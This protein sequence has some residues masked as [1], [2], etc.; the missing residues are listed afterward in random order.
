MARI[1]CKYVGCTFLDEGLCSAT[2]I[3]LDPDEGCL[4]FTQVGDPFDDDED[5]GGNDD[6]DGYDEWD[7]EEDYNDSLYGDDDY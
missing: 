2:T 5:W 7:D 4:T 1:R 6:L 3:Q